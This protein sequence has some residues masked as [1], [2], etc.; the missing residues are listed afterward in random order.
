MT[1]NKINLYNTDKYQ[2]VFPNPEIEEISGEAVEVIISADGTEDSASNET[3][4]S[5]TMNASAGV[6]FDTG[7]ITSYNTVYHTKINDNEEVIHEMDKAT[8]RTA[9]ICLTICDSSNMNTS[10]KE[11]V[12]IHNNTS[13]AIHE[14]DLVSIGSS[15]VD[16]S[17]S[18]SVVGN[19]IK[20]S[21][22]CDNNTT[23]KGPVNYLAV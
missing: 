12:I 9:K 4:S 7:I 18:V 17:F 6:W 8:F 11:I 15:P 1:R 22:T 23:L 16:P 14:T 3:P 5:I 21:A 2:A 20:L 10:Y 19:K 13:A